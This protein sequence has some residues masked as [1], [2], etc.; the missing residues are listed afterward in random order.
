MMS[1]RPYGRGSQDRP[2]AGETTM[3]PGVMRSSSHDAWANPGGLLPI[4]QH[5]GTTTDGCW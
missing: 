5:D 1:P 3:N 2:K 4:T